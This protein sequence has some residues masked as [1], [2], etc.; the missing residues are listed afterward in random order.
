MDNLHKNFAAIAVTGELYES[1]KDLYDVLAAYIMIIIK[2]DKLNGFTCADLTNQINR[3]NSFSV[4]ESVVKSALTRLG[5]RRDQGRYWVDDGIKCSID[6]DKLEELTRQNDAV[7]KR[8]FEFIS[9]ENNNTLSTDDLKCI[10]SQFYGFLHNPEYDG[11]YTI[12]ISKFL[13]ENSLDPLF[14]QALSRIKD[15]LLVYEGI[16]FSPEIGN[17]GK[18]DIPLDI[19][20]ELEVIFYIAGYNGEIHKE[21]YG[22]LID[23]I[24]E[25]N[26][27]NSKKSGGSNI[28]KLFYTSDIK[29]EIENY[30]STAE[31][32]FERN[33]VVDPSKSAMM[34]ILNGVKTKREIQV[35]KVQLYNFLSRKRILEKNIDFYTD[36]NRSYNII[37]G[38]A[39]QYNVEKIDS[40]R[41]EEYIRRCTDKINQINIIRKNKNSSLKDARAILLTANG[42]ILRCAY[43]PNAYQEGDTPKAVNLD[44][45]VNRF[46]YKLNKGFGKGESPKSIDIISRAQMVIASMTASKVSRAYDDIKSKYDEGSI[47]DDEVAGILSELRRVSINPEDI[48]LAKINE[49]IS[50][51][52]DYDLNKKIEDL[53]REEIARQKDKNTIVKLQAK[54]ETEKT[55]DWLI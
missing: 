6:T 51:L 16:C 53:K 10:E 48:T 23:Y 1:G 14:N 25:I 27:I 19:Y 18:W 44:Y 29:T 11:E 8:L 47:S 49:Q 42:T 22:Q 28:I 50:F 38:N 36:E 30:F 40:E 7:V 55:E 12:L 32:I 46:W 13:M 17:G 45:L 3:T 31:S 33:E 9:K 5:L 4:S 43:M 39:Y 2:N 54:L 35:K 34:Y 24:D 52:T 41:G 15:G 21:I 20:L 37:D 26:D